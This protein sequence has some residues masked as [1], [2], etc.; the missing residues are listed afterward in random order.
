METSGVKGVLQVPMRRDW[1][2]EIRRCDGGP[3]FAPIKLLWR[4]ET[5]PQ[6]YKYEPP[7]TRCNKIQR[8]QTNW[9]WMYGY[10]QRLI[11]I[12]TANTRLHLFANKDGQGT[13]LKEAIKCQDKSCQQNDNAKMTHTHT[14]CIYIPRRK[15]KNGYVFNWCKSVQWAA[16]LCHILKSQGEVACMPKPK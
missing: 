15:R 14:H 10:N 8:Y 7:D 4:E 3:C 9:I 16:H 5:G 1:W 13:W 12:L 11:S 6:L 2:L